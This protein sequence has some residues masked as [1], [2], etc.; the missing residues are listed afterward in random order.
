MH[1]SY[2]NHHR[3]IGGKKISSAA[4]PIVGAVGSREFKY[5]GDWGCNQL[6]RWRGERKLHGRWRCEG[7][8]EAKGEKTHGRWRVERDGE[9]RGGGEREWE[10]KRWRRD[11]K[12]KDVREREREKERVK[13]RVRWHKR[14]WVKRL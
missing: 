14:T 11:E 1:L 9:A 12:V 13:K 3:S 6:G 4:S 10:M 5:I 8:E 2:T 7:D